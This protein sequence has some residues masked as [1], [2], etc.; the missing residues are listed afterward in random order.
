MRAKSVFDSAREWV[1]AIRSVC[2]MGCI[3]VLD[4]FLSVFL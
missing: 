2:G 4:I 1:N 3:L